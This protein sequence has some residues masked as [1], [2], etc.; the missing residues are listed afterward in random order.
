MALKLRQLY[1]VNDEIAKLTIVHY[2]KR[3]RIRQGITEYIFRTK[4]G[5][6]ISIKDISKIKEMTI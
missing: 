4:A 5:K 3:P 1:Q 6:T 2:T